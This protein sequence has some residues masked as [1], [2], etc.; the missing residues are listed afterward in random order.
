[1]QLLSGFRHPNIVQYVGTA[2][3]G[4]CLYIF[5]ELIRVGRPAQPRPPAPG[6]SAGRPQLLLLLLLLLGTAFS[7]RARGQ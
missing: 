7:L 5:L 6:P 3:H 2:R 1:V 4:A